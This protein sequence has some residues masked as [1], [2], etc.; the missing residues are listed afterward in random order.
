MGHMALG[1]ENRIDFVIGQGAGGDGNRKNQVG[2]QQMET[3]SIL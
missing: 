3:L 2:L 1:M